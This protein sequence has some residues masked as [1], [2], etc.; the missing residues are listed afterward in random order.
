MP[1]AKSKSAPARGLGGERDFARLAV[2]SRGGLEESWHLG[3]VAVATPT[4]ELRFRAGN[5]ELAT[6]VRSAA[7]PWQALPFVLAGGME[8]YGLDAADLALMCASHGGTPAHARRVALLLERGDLPAA[9]L[10]CGVHEPLDEAAAQGLRRSGREPSALHNNCSGNHAGMLLSCQLLGLETDDYVAPDHPLQLQV[11]RHLASFCAVP[12]ATV[13]IGVDG[14]GAPAYRLGLR[15]AARGYAALAAPAAAGLAGA[16]TGA[17]QRIAE[18]IAEAPEMVAGPGR[19]TT[20][21]IEAT[22][23][24]VLGK[25]G[26]EGFYALAVRAPEPLGIA[27]KIA[28][29]GE[30][31]RDGVVIEVLRQLGCLDQRELEALR[32]FHIVPLL[33]RRQAIVGE[34]RPVVEL[35]PADSH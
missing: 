1:A 18:A 27:L 3:A 2:A 6:F 15:A 29:G 30:R 12:A 31:C 26:A 16:E 23:G 14:C 4:G 11:L 34:I 17:A 35:V 24:R 21:L 32:D 9:A 19:F 25:E 10:A 5:P 22:A 20:R 33:N 13:G 8:R 28:D 7:K